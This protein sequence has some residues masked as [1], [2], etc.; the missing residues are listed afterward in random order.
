MRY[1][2]S[3]RN[4]TEKIIPDLGSRGVVG[5]EVGHMKGRKGKGWKGKERDEMG[6]WEGGRMG[7]WDGK[8]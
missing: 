2:R 5:S 6:K 7:G 8:R 3:T 1:Q 4:E